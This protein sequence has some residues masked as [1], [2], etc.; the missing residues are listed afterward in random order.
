MCFIQPK[1]ILFL[2]VLLEYLKILLN[3]EAGALLA[4]LVF[5]QFRFLPPPIQ[6]LSELCMMSSVFYGLYLENLKY[7]VTIP[8]KSPALFISRGAL[9]SIYHNCSS[10]G[11]LKQIPQSISGESFS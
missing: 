9:Q 6:R 10:P 4:S 1:V 11:N 3:T 7:S 8:Y 5:L 2:T